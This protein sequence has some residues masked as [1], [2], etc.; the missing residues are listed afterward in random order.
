M[1][2]AVAITHAP[3]M[4]CAQRVPPEKSLSLLQRAVCLLSETR[5]VGILS[6]GMQTACVWGSSLIN[7]TRQCYSQGQEKSQQLHQSYGN[8]GKALRCH[9]CALLP[10]AT[11]NPTPFPITPLVRYHFTS[12]MKV[13][14]RAETAFRFISQANDSNNVFVYTSATH[15]W[16]LDRYQK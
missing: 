13:L 6:Q 14:F 3:S 10:L 16:R 2:V 11:A 4:P 8:S 15:Y 9:S 1:S 7:L 5:I 12:E